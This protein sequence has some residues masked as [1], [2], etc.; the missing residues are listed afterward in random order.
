[1]NIVYRING[2]TVS[3]QQF[4]RKRMLHGGIAEMVRTGAVPDLQTDTSYIARSYSQRPE[5]ERRQIAL[6]AKQCGM[7][8]EQAY[9][10]TL[11]D[12][13][14]DPAAMFESRS[15]M[16]RRVSDRKVSRDEFFKPKH[17]LHPRLVQEVKR[18][19]A[20]K[21]PDVLRRDQRE[22]EAE[23]IAKHGTKG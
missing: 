16:R 1:M 18:E 11:A 14:L 21:N 13:P 12:S 15:A 19:M 10:P 3:Q 17:R 22:L 8:E 20:E 7:A 9:D 6:R 4:R 23:I 2:Q 5:H